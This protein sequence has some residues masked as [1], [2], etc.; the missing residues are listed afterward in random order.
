[1]DVFTESAKAEEPFG[2]AHDEAFFNGPAL[3]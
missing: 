1:M 3:D 2:G